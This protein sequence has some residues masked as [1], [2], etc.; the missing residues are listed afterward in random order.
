MK[1]FYARE[2]KAIAEVIDAIHVPRVGDLVFLKL[3]VPDEPPPGTFFK[4]T[5]VAWSTQAQ[6]GESGEPHQLSP[7]DAYVLVE[8]AEKS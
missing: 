2:G 4:V 7:G 6:Q 5:M 3:G 1:I 8:P